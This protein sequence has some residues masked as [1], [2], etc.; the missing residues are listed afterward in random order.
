MSECARPIEHQAHF[1]ILSLSVGAQE[2]RPARVWSGHSIRQ[3]LGPSSRCY[4]E[5]TRWRWR[6][7]CRWRAIGRCAPF[8]GPGFSRPIATRA[9]SCVIC[10]RKRSG[11]RSRWCSTIAVPTVQVTWMWSK[12]WSG[13]QRATST[14]RFICF[15]DSVACSGASAFS[16]LIKRGAGRRLPFSAKPQ[17]ATKP[18]TRHTDLENAKDR[19]RW[20][21][22]HR[23]GYENALV[24]VV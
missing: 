9:R 6:R 20:W 21:P 23:T 7:T 18:K 11:L 14:A 10:G 17:A 13:F 8:G 22:G 2:L 1:A 15:R 12:F 19:K 4:G 3:W 5:A 16:T 24:P